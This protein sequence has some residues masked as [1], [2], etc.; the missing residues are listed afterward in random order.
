MTTAAILVTAALVTLGASA[1]APPANA[2][3][4]ERHESW[5]V[6]PGLNSTSGSNSV[7]AFTENDDAKLS[8]V[9]RDSE[10]LQLLVTFRFIYSYSGRGDQ[11]RAIYRVDNN[12]PITQTA[13]VGF[14]D[15][16]SPIRWALSG[17]TGSLSQLIEQARGGDRLVFRML[18][19]HR[20][21]M[22]ISTVATRTLTKDFSLDGFNAAA[23]RV[24]EACS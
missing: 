14:G 8:L 7:I 18:N 17:D 1:G 22:H 3:E 23:A 5:T 21:G 24:L 20:G 10:S 11:R 4:T 12:E 9:C 15:A 6:R 13:R 2:Q 19:V 16:Y